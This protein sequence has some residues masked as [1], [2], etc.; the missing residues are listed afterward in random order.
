MS[1]WASDKI[2]GAACHG[3]LTIGGVSMNR[4]AWAVLN[5]WVFWQPAAVRGA[6]NQVPGS[7]GVLPN[8]RR[9]TV[10]THS[11]ELLII[12]TCDRFGDPV[13][14]DDWQTQL[15]LNSEWLDEN[16]FTPPITLEG[17]RTAVLTLPNGA[18]RTGQ[19]HLETPVYGVTAPPAI[20]CTI[21]ISIPAGQ[22]GA[23]SGP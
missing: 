22:L 18:T 17:T 14:I 15:A 10:T 5:N 4:D 7:P 16:V 23:I 13:P 6:D 9:K 20:T 8:R 1:N 2:T 3:T 21:D 12:G 19:I 11:L